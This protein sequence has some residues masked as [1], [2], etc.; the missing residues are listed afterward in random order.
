MQLRWLRSLFNPASSASFSGLPATRALKTLGCCW[1]ARR[2]GT[3]GTAGT[4]RLRLRL[5]AVG[6]FA[7]RAAST[8]CLR[9]AEAGVCLALGP[10]LGASRADLGCQQHCAGSRA[11]LGPILGASRAHLGFHQHSLPLGCYGWWAEAGV[12]FED[13]AFKR[14]G[15]VLAWLRGPASTWL[16][17]AWLRGPGL[18]QHLQSE[19]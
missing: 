17:R 9:F 16:G 7:T 11:D 12:C 6:I 18:A 10:I 4:A 1:T 15:S 8:A 13:K 3:A 2:A 5:R 19:A 14:L